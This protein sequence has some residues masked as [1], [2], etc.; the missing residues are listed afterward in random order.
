MSQKLN[1]DKPLEEMDP[2]E[3]LDEYVALVSGQADERDP[4]KGVKM[5]LAPKL[6]ERMELLKEFIL[7][8]MISVV[9]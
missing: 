8:G 2:K 1:Y 9:S 5:G 7:S 6:K 4:R 3:I